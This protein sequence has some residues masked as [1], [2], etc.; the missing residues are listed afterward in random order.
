[1][2]TYLLN[3]I[4]IF[5]RLRLRLYSWSPSKLSWEE[6]NTVYVPNMY[7]VSTLAWKRDGSRIVCGTL[8]GGIELFESV[9]K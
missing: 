6:E 8:C 4:L 5:I 3:K 1:M 7:N 9:I 2:Y